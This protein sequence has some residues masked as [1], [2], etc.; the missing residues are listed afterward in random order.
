MG[1]GMHSRPAENAPS[2]D[3]KQYKPRFK[4]VP[5]LDSVSDSAESL[6]MGA[7]EA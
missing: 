2:A 6:E 4:L 5:K 3:T 7:V 1:P